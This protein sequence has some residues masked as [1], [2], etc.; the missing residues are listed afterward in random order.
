MAVSERENCDHNDDYFPF[1]SQSGWCVFVWWYWHC[2]VRLDL[3]QVQIKNLPQTLGDG[4]WGPTTTFD[5]SMKWRLPP[6]YHRAQG[7]TSM[8]RHTTGRLSETNINRVRT[9]HQGY[10]RQYCTTNL[11]F[12]ESRVQ[13]YSSVPKWGT[14]QVPVVFGCQVTTEHQ[15]FV[16]WVATWAVVYTVLSPLFRDTDC[17]ICW[18]TQWDRTSNSNGYIGNFFICLRCDRRLIHSNLN[19]QPWKCSERDWSSLSR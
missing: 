1:K 17:H 11:W 9:T 2:T 7:Q 12:Q 14:Y 13:D 15:H 3:H 16:L 18:S 5:V 4:N 19:Y 8:Y 10:T 6:C